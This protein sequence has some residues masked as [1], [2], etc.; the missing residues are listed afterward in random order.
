VLGNL[1]SGDWTPKDFVYQ[2]TNTLATNAIRR[3]TVTGVGRWVHQWDGDVRAFGALG[4]GVANDAPAM[5]AAFDYGARNGIAI[6]SRP[7]AIHKIMGP[8][9]ATNSNTYF[10]GQGA[11]IKL[12]VINDLATAASLRTMPLGGISPYGQAKQTVFATN[13]TFRNFSLIG[14][15]LYNTGNTNK[16]LFYL[17]GCDGCTV[18]NVYFEGGPHAAW[19]LAVDSSNFRLSNLYG[20]NRGSIYRDGI[21]ISSGTNGVMSNIL[22]YSGDDGIVFGN[23]ADRT[24]QDI[25]LSSFSSDSSHGFPIKIYTADSLQPNGKNP[26][27]R[28]QR[29][30]ISDGNIAA[31]LH[32]NSAITVLDQGWAYQGKNITNLVPSRLLSD[33]KFSNINIRDDGTNKS[34]DVSAIYLVGGERISFDNVDVLTPYWLTVLMASTRDVYFRNCY[35]GAPRPSAS[36]TNA[37]IQM[38][39]NTPTAHGTIT[40]TYDNIV[41]RGC[42]IYGRNDIEL[43]TVKPLNV[44]RLIFDNNDFYIGSNGPAALWLNVTTTNVIVSNNRFHGTTTNAAI[45][46]F[47]QV[48]TNNYFGNNWFSPTI[49]SPFSGSRPAGVFSRQDGWES[50]IMALNTN[51]ASEMDYRLNG[52]GMHISQATNSSKSAQTTIPLFVETEG[53]GTV[54]AWRRAATASQVALSFPGGIPNWIGSSGQ[55]VIADNRT[56]NASHQL[57]ILMPSWDVGATYHRVLHATVL[58]NGMAINYGGGSANS[59]PAL[60]HNFWTGISNVTSGT[61]RLI[62]QNEGDVNFVPMPGDPA[63]AGQGDMFFDSVLNEFRVVDGGSATFR[64]LNGR[65]GVSTLVAGSVTVTNAYFIAATLVQATHRGVSLGGVA[66]TLHC[67]SALGVLTIRS[68][69]VTDTNQVAWYA[70]TP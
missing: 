16:I 1:S 3:S 30:V 68:T 39:A 29:I 2:P 40:H 11:V 31:G 33:I 66:G 52:F 15:N 48:G 5:N 63:T 57:N 49:L 70:H 41:F 50:R 42:Q 32:R 64:P 21:H 22:V 45:L 37:T 6:K 54:Q 9:F 44:N 27:N 25:S 18:D 28:T 7:G 4:D 26:T 53:I 46:L 56:A 10:D 58:G 14:E 51:G 67:D 69:S 61:V 19:L 23:D 47:G 8:L 20:E 24:L 17:T 43:S 60:S 34:V 13:S 35:L 38:L 62:V 55:W 65:R 59:F 12:N 36:Q